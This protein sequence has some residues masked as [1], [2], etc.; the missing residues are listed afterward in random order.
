MDM[1]LPTPKLTR[2]SL[3]KGIGGMTFSFALATDGTRILSAAA[4]T[5]AEP[6]KLSPWVRIAPNGTITILTVTEMG[7]GSG[8][9][10]PLMI[11]EEMDADW[12]KVVLDWAPSD[13][14]VYG[15]PD[16]KGN[17]QMAITGSRAVMMYWDD[18]RTAGAQVRKVLIANAAEKWKVDPKTLKTEPGLVVNPKTGQRLT[19]G[20]I[21]AFGK[22][23]EPLPAVDKSELK[24]R[25]Q[26]RLIGKSV[27]RRDLPAKVQGKAQY[28]IDVKLPGMAYASA[29]HSPVHGNQPE[30]WNDAEIKALP[31]VLGTVKL[32]HGV[33]VIAETYPQAMAARRA[34]RVAW[35]KGKTNGFDSVK[36]LDGYEKLLTDASVQP[37]P[38]FTHGNVDA[39]FSG[40]AK[41]VK[42]GY[43]SDYSYHAQMEPLNAVA[44]FNEAGDRL[45][46]WDGSQDLGRSRELIAK[47]MGL[48]EDQVDVHQCYLGG[49][50]GR[51]SLADYALEAAMAAKAVKRP[52]KLIW[53]RE[54]DIAH[55]M[56]RPISFQQIE[57]ACDASGKVVGWKHVGIGDDGGAS[58]ITGGMRIAS[59]YDLPNQHLELRN[60]DEGVR[61]KHWRAV[62]HNFNLFAIEGMVDQIAASQGMDPVEFRLKNMSVTPKAQRVIEAAAKL[63]NWKAKRPQG[64]ALG[65]AMSER[66]GSLGACVVECSLNQK[67]GA[68]RVHKVWLAIDGGTIVQPVAAKANVESGIVYGLSTALHE[69]VT[70]RDGMVEQSN[71]N[72]YTVMRMSDM[73]E[74]IDIAFVPSDAPPTGLGEIGTP[75]VMPAIAN[76]FAK[77]TGKRLYHMPFTP[78]RVT[79]ALKA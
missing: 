21:A 28:A 46:V 38:V 29:L 55:G 23:P 56:F 13:S 41:V 63:A 74:E 8:T 53:T 39:A 67:A 50:F 65:I 42:A 70:V 15:W 49:G 5:A 9:S 31:G 6:A 11:A 19:Y 64:R 35:T 78:E 44:R 17:R 47:G 77:L 25:A 51:R 40:A 76:A 52:V 79:A 57:A 59:Y 72:D 58:F 26:F 2:R 48:K 22:V 33:G 20:Q 61:V 62:A 71:F 10:I 66:S 69:R 24:T 27:P 60:V 68:I 43:R 54:E 34:L 3:L 75:C 36:A 1:T 45:E 7:Q 30:S 14:A 16:P 18:L 37:K 73:P 32:P 12:S 4:A